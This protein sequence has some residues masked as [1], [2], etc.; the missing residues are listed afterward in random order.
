MLDSGC[1]GRVARCSYSCPPHPAVLLP[2][3]LPSDAIH[4]RAFVPHLYFCVPRPRHQ[5]LG[6][7]RFHF[8]PTPILR[9]HVAR[10]VLQVAVVLQT[11]TKNTSSPTSSSPT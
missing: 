4:W 7:Q 6:R 1:G 5:R 3:P 11:P 2:P 8:S 10:F 9:Q